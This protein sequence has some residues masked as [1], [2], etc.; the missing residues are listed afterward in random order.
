MEAVTAEG[1]AFSRKGFSV[2]K[3]SLACV[4]GALTG[5]SSVAG[6]ETTL[7]I[8]LTT[9][10]DS[11]TS[12][13]ISEA[14]QKAINDNEE[15][16]D[17]Y[18][19]RILD[20][21]PNG[22]AYR[23][24]GDSTEGSIFSTYDV[25]RFSIEAQS[26]IG[27]GFTGEAPSETI[28]CD[29]DIKARTV[30]SDKSTAGARLAFEAR[31]GAEKSP[32]VN[33]EGDFE[34]GRGFLDFSGVDATLAGQGTIGTLALWQ[35]GQGGEQGPFSTKVTIQDNPS[36]PYKTFLKIDTLDV[37][38]GTL[39]ILGRYA[40]TFVHV[41]KLGSQ[42]SY[43][44]N[45]PGTGGTVH[46]TG[47][48]ALSL[49]KTNEDED[50][51]EIQRKVLGAVNDA[52]MVC[53]SERASIVLDRLE[54][55]PIVNKEGQSFLICIGDESDAPEKD[56]SGIFVGKNGRVVWM[57]SRPQET[58]ETATDGRKMQRAPSTESQ[59]NLTLT[60]SED[61]E[62]VING[63]DGKEA[64]FNLNGMPDAL[65][66]NGNIHLIGT[67]IGRGTIV[68][69]GDGT[70]RIERHLMQNAFGLK[71]FHCV[72][73]TENRLYAEAFSSP[74]EEFIRTAIEDTKVGE[75]VFAQL[76]DTAVFL[77]FSSRTLVYAERAFDS[78]HDRLLE[79]DIPR[80]A[81]D[82]H[83]WVTWET[84]KLRLADATNNATLT[85]IRLGCDTDLTETWSASAVFSGTKF[86]ADDTRGEAINMDGSVASVGASLEK[87]FSDKSALRF[88]VTVAKAQLTAKQ[89]AV[90]QRLKTE[91]ELLLA[92]LG[93]RVNTTYGEAVLVKPFVGI[94][95]YY[96][97]MSE[98]D[99]LDYDQNKGHDG[100]GFKTGAKKRVWGS[101]STGAQISTQWDVASY[102][103]K[104]S[105]G[106]VG[107]AYVG[108]R[109]WKAQAALATG[110]SHLDYAQFEATGAWSVRAEAA[111][112]LASSRSVPVTEGGIFGFGAKPTGKTTTEDWH[113]D[114]K[115]GI[116]RSERSEKN[117]YARIEY[118]QNW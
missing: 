107:K 17:F 39:D 24:T 31:N 46:V 68:S 111:L 106:F 8:E 97:K 45:M 60:L 42:D 61:A 88:G 85:S 10:D 96:A 29:V 62:L 47:K 18:S 94:N 80:T 41:G 95:L 51:S 37:T 93:A 58:E 5:I 75:D 98:G 87:R 110:Q 105:L 28:N 74:G 86:D 53:G 100:I 64:T 11:V 1:G 104:P 112:K 14:I 91:P 43:G 32:T 84:E 72:Q 116:A 21:R 30:L 3:F 38:D 40:G 81:Q 9:Q 15:S 89:L 103:I 33:L 35:H 27:M 13:I 69:T 76:I 57:Y 34:F 114:L 48:A 118:R 92:G 66:T 56:S 78:A 70:F 117:S 54:S 59:G 19:I 79:R 71:A 102:S 77:P 113:V 55:I 101:V 23:V 7:P 16:Y 90:G 52:T 83:W 22:I 63:W 82:D 12:E 2:K 49:I 26:G 115:V 44:E 25:A 20:S 73:E 109:K 65:I 99:I 6:A 36:V 4:V 67:K 108:D 50:P